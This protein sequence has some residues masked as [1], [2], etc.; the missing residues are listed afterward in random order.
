M[1]LEKLETKIYFS[2]YI[3]NEKTYIVKEGLG[4]NN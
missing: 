1:P 3:V 2:T 4:R